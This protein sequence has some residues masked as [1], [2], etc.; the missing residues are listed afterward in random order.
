MSICQNCNYE[1][2]LLSHRQKYKCSLCSKLYSKKE[3]KNREFREW[4]KRQRD[5][6]IEEYEK[7]RKEELMQ[8][9]DLKKAIKQLFKRSYI[10]IRE[11]RKERYLKNKETI[12]QRWK[13]YYSKNR[14]RLLE[15]DDRWRQ[16]NQERIS[17]TNKG[18]L[19]RNK[20]KRKEF[21]KAYNLRN[22]GLERQKL[23]LAYWR[24]KQKL[25]ADAYLKNNKERASTIKFQEFSPT[26]ALCEQLES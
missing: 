1:L 24:K 14:E 20:E 13:E 19:E 6:T 5:L 25:L 16:N 7:E 22:I 26:F 21:L 15:Q 10:Y 2:V 4:N 23:R 18:W 8:L 3:I 17:L 9:K 11:C 12:K